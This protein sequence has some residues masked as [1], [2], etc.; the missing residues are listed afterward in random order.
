MS[1]LTRR[2]IGIVAGIIYALIYG[3]WTMFITGGGHGNFIWLFLFFFPEVL[4]LYF[5]LMCFL[6][7]D[8]RSLFSKV[9]FGVLI[10]VN[11]I[12][13]SVLITG[14]INEP[15][16]GDGPSDYSRMVQANGIGAVVLCAGLHFLPTFVFIGVLI[17]AISIAD[18][19][20]SEAYDQKY[21]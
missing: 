10:A 9:A 20:D 6:A 5:P 17:R 13:S 4:G 21:L 14:W 15:S 19:G 18:R 1:Y 16:T 2:I 3:F 11:V 12:V 7:T 8:L